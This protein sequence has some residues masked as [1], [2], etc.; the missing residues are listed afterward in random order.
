MTT[1]LFVSHQS[2]P[3]GKRIQVV[4][5][6]VDESIWISFRDTRQEAITHQ[7]TLTV[8]TVGVEAVADYWFTIANH[9]RDDSDNRAG[10]FGKID[11]GVG[12][13]GGNRNSFFTDVYDTHDGLLLLL[14]APRYALR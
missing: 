5:L 10:H 12:N 8:A 14:V 2:L 7:C 13:W 11:I 9:I 1:W 3:D 6:V 4:V